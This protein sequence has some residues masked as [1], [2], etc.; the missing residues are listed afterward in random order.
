MAAKYTT[1]GNAAAREGEGGAGTLGRR[2]SIIGAV[3]LVF[4]VANVGLL[5]LRCLED[6]SQ[7]K[8]SID[9][10]RTLQVSHLSDNASV[11]TS[12]AGQD[13]SDG[14]VGEWQVT[15]IVQK[16][17]RG[18]GLRSS[19]ATSTDQQQQPIKQKSA[20]APPAPFALMAEESLGFYDASQ[21][22][23]AQR[24]ELKKRNRAVM[25]HRQMD[26][27]WLSKISLVRGHGA[28][29]YQ[30]FFE[31]DWSC[32][33]EMRLGTLGDGGKWV[34]D[35]DRIISRSK[36][37]GKP[38]LVYSVGG[39]N[40]WS[41]ED[42]VYKTL[43]CEV[44][45]FDHTVATPKA[46]PEHINFHRWGI[47]QPGRGAS[48]QADNPGP[49]TAGLNEIITA[50]GHENREI[51]IFKID[52]EG[53]EFK[54]LTPLL[55]SGAWRKKPPIRQVLIEVH[56]FGNHQ[57]QAVEMNKELLSAFLNNGYVMFH[58]EPN[59][60][61]AGGNCVEFAFLQ[62]DLPTPPDKPT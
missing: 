21:Y 25:W 13:S 26:P 36:A 55:T 24:W 46:K 42:S 49:L 47:D 61:Y 59:I 16:L 38:C 35:P 30:M 58:K 5:L 51:D 23:E 32:E 2:W 41:F 43:G 10:M 7:L 53:A 8:K 57:Q 4:L 29:F 11:T 50:L 9:A 60:Q 45:T 15:Q 17:L 22:S 1:V 3:L 28:T 34:C 14:V 12:G 20:A 6:L 44:H 52:V 48:L 18:A 40:E 56:V 39:S 62:L 19:D 27:N 33:F 37:S 31:P 54:S